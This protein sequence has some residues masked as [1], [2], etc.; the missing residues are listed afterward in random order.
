MTAIDRLYDLGTS[1][2]LDDLSRERITSGNIDELKAT[3]S[4]VGVTT[5]PAIFASA[6]SKGNA[7]DAQLAE[8]KERN[9]SVDEAV[10]AMSV[11]DVQD[12]CDLFLDVYESTGGKD[13]RVSIVVFKIIAED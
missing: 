2:W 10:Y 9:A 13:G 7:Y 8:L 4:I 3:K 6:M 12:A 11:K 1:T 5:N